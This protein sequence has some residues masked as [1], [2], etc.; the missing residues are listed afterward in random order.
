MDY[1]PALPL[2]MAA[3][4]ARDAINLARVTSEFQVLFQG[5]LDDGPGT[6]ADGRAWLR[7]AQ[8]RRVMRRITEYG[9]A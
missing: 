1:R 5:Y 9:D 6:M 4:H 2:A 3:Y 7:W 8:I